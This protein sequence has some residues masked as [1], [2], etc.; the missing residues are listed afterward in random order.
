M[1]IKKCA[2]I[3]GLIALAGCSR[4]P[5]GTVYVVPSPAVVSPVYVPQPVIMP[6]VRPVYYCYPRPIYHHFGHGFHHYPHHHP[7]FGGR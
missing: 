7:H 5:E 6:V 2:I 3:S 1:N 4:I